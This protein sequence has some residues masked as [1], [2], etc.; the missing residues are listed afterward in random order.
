MSKTKLELTRPWKYK[1]YRLEPRILIHKTDLSGGDSTTENMLIHWDNLLAL[2]ALE[3]EYAGKVKC[4]YIDPPYNTWSAFEHY[5]DWLEHSLWLSMMYER[6]RL[7]HSLLRNDW[8]I[9]FVQLD[10][11]EVHYCKVI[12]DELFWRENF[13]S[14]IAVKSS[15]PSWLKTAHKTKTIIKQKDL[16]L[17]YKK[18]DSIDINP[19]YMWNNKRDTH[20]SYYFDFEKRKV[21]KL[22]DILKEK[23]LLKDKESLWDL[24]INDKSFK[25][26][27]IKNKDNIFRTAP[28]MPDDIKKK[29]KENPDQVI[30]YWDEEWRQYAFWWNRMTFLSKAVQELDTGEIDLWILLCDFWWDIDFQNSQNEWS[31]SFPASKK[32]E[33]LIMRI[34]KLCTK[35]WDIVLDSFLWSW[36]TCSVAHKMWRKWI[37][38]ELGEHAYTHCK[39]RID[40]VID[41]EQWGISKAVNR[42]GGWWYKFY[43][44]WPSVLIQDSYWN[45]I[46]N[47]EFNSADLIQSLCKIENFTYKAY[48]DNIKHGYST[49]KDFI[50]VTTRH[51]TQ[52]ILNDIVNNS[53]KQWETILVV[54][55]TFASDLELPECIQIKKIPPEIL[56]KCEYNKNDYSLPV[57]DTV[58]E[59]EEEIE[60]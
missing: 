7:I 55:K 40:K 9:I 59:D 31:V 27:Y 51:I 46:I 5:D 57:T 54:A 29:S 47:P 41:G 13:I 22:S 36:T 35:P 20:Y 58:V 32:P 6:L 37:G 34:L 11:I 26:F 16:V 4:V 30:E 52:D 48:L 38:I 18:W 45:Y 50:H 2:K 14:T 39:A 1:D 10:D 33:R 8:W 21:I 19:Q 15:T 25:N 56:G 42:Q 3:Q 60:E 24:N 28:T 44:L 12:M 17:V 49:E 43:E 23:W 53:L